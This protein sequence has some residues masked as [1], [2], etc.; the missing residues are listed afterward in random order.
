MAEFYAQVKFAHVLCVTL[1]G[2]LFA[3]RG[4]M[5]LAR[6][7][8]ANHPAL[9]YLSYAIDT[10]LLT[11]ALL[12]VTIVHQY[13]FVQS[14]LTVKVLML[15]VYVVLGMYA[16]RR[17]RTPAVRVACY[18]AALGVY[19]FIVSVARAHSPWGVLGAFLSSSHSAG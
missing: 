4:L 7:D 8:H 12:L 15:V 16:L 18:F 6:S 5:M 14:W 10:A 17:G 3:L 13:P 11:A 2:S 1:S 9:R 19:L